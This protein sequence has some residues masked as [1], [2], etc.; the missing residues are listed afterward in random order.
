MVSPMYHSFML[1]LW[2]DDQADDCEWHSQVDHMQS[3]RRWSF[4]TV[5][6][7][8]DFLRRQAEDPTVLDN[9]PGE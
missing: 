4:D 3:G 8:L 7:L 2:R 9:S 6:T 1:R 5:E